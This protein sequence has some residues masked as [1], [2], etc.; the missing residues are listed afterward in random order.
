MSSYQK[1]L[2]YVKLK[3]RYPTIILWDLRKSLL[4]PKKSGDLVLAWLCVWKGGIMMGSWVKVCRWSNANFARPVYFRKFENLYFNGW[5]CIKLKKCK[6]FEWNNFKPPNSLYALKNKLHLIT[7]GEIT[8]MFFTLRTRSSQ[9]IQRWNLKKG[10][11]IW[12]HI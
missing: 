5:K 1:L 10:R 11:I 12:I 8:F 2:L 9:I 6:Y 3:S 4:T 7:A